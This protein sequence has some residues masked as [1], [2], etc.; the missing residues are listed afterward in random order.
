MGGDYSNPFRH[1]SQEV[2]VARKAA[3]ERAKLFQVP[4]HGHETQGRHGLYAW[5]QARGRDGVTPEISI[6]R[7]EPGFCGEIIIELA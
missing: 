2:F 3:Q 7:A 4:G 1:I 5:V 6:R